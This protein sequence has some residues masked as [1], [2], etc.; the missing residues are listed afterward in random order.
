MIIININTYFL[1][2]SPRRHI[3]PI[4][5]FP[6]IGDIYQM[7]PVKNYTP[8][9]QNDVFPLSTVQIVGNYIFPPKHKY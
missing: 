1:S 2:I 5:P 7:L 4:I 9:F 3:L 6:K 8:L